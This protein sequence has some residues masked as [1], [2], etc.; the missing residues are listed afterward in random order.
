MKK[1]I[2]IILCLLTAAALSSCS[3]KGKEDETTE[4]QY[5]NKIIKEYFDNRETDENGENTTA[6]PISPYVNADGVELISSSTQLKPGQR[7]DIVF[8]GSPYLQYIVKIYDDNGDP[9]EFEFEERANSDQNGQGDFS[10]TVPEDAE[11]GNY[12]I[13]LKV[14]GGQRYLQTTITVTE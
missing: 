5:D 7:G 12:I 3:G 10:Y 14:D 2:C 1:F 11:P 13:M 9:A 4:K 6:S 8:K